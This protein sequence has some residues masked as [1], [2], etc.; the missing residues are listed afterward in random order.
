MK[1]TK[2]DGEQVHSIKQQMDAN[3]TGWSVYRSVNSERRLG[4]T[5]GREVLLLTRTPATYI[6]YGALLLWDTI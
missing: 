2:P 5:I 1:Y 4:V 3:Y 6:I